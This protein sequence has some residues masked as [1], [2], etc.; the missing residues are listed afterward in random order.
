MNFKTGRLASV[1]IMSTRQSWLPSN[2]HQC[3]STDTFMGFE[4]LRQ[5]L[6]VSNRCRNL[7]A[8]EFSCWEGETTL[9]GKAS[10]HCWSDSTA[11]VYMSAISER[12]L[13]G[14]KR[15]FGTHPIRWRD[16]ACGVACSE[17]DRVLTWSRYGPALTWERSRWTSCW[18]RVGQSCGPRRSEHNHMRNGVSQGHGRVS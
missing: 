10:W 16:V 7:S 2:V 5:C 17:C 18:S 11:L 15:R 4:F 9:T 1:I 6:W 13:D 3:S 12:K 14:K 8:G